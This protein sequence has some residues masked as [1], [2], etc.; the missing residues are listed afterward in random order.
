MAETIT[1]HLRLVPTAGSP[2]GRCR[3]AL[4]DLGL[5][6]FIFLVAAFPLASAIA[7]AGEWD[8]RSL[9]VGAVGVLLAGRELVVPIL[10]GIRGRA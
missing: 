6:L 9:G 2:S 3:P 7:G 4:H 1:G 10:A 8:Q 5:T